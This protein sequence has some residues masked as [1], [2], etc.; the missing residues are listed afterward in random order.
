MKRTGHLTHLI[1]I[2]RIITPVPDSIRGR[3]IV[4][5][6]FLRSFV[7]LFV[8]LSAILREN[9]LIDLHEIFREGVQEWPR[10]DLITFLLNSEKPRDAQHG[11]GFVVLSHRGLFDLGCSSALSRVLTSLNKFAN[12]EVE[13]RRVGV[14]NAPVGSRDPVYNFPCCWVIRLETSDDIMTSLQHWGGDI[15][16]YR[17]LISISIKSH[18]VTPIWSLVC[19]FLNCRLNPSAVVVQLVANSVHTTDADATLLDSWVASAV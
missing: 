12:S 2:P 6:R 4:F 7:C 18:V 1:L 15:T 10:D 5:D 17:Y 9:G 19:H 8:Y 14:A 13:L 16:W 3:G 11:A